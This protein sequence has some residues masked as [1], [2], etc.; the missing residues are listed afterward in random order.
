[1]LTEVLISK[2][3]RATV[4]QAE[5]NYVGSITIDADL[6][7]ACEMKANQKVLITSMSNGSRIETYI[8]RGA[9]GT[10][11]IC[12]NGPS[13]HLVSPGDEILIMAFG[14]V[15]IEQAENI[16]PKVIFPDENNRIAVSAEAAYA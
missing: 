13:A 8:I 16:Q 14:L 6:L 2:I 12:L 5:L 10:G 1:M 15:E 4:T 3:H 7:D 11:E 9:A